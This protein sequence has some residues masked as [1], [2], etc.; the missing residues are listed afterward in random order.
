MV[1]RDAMTHKAY[2]VNP[3]VASVPEENALLAI[4]EG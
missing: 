3:L 4:G 1:C 2:P